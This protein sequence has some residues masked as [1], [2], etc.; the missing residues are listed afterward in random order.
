[1]KNLYFLPLLLS[2]TP[3][4]FAGVDPEVHKICL[5]ARDYAGCIKSLPSGFKKDSKIKRRNE[6]TY[7][8]RDMPR[9]DDFTKESVVYSWKYQATDRHAKIQPCL[10]FLANKND[11][12]HQEICSLTYEN[13]IKFR[14]HFISVPL[15][16]NVVNIE[17]TLTNYYNKNTDHFV[18]YEIT[19]LALDCKLKKQLERRVDYKFAKNPNQKKSNFIREKGYGEWKIEAADDYML[20]TSC[21]ENPG[22]SRAN[23]GSNVLELE[24]DLENIQSNGDLKIIPIFTKGKEAFIVNNCKNNNWA[25]TNKLPAK[26]DDFMPISTY[27]HGSQSNLIHQLSCFNNNKGSFVDKIFSKITKSNSE[28]KTSAE[29]KAY[30]ESNSLVKLG[31]KKALDF[32]HRD[33]IPHYNK[34]IELN[35]KNADAYVSRGFAKFYLSGRDGACEDWKKGADLGDE[36]ALDLLEQFCR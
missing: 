31:K 6:I 27:K 15:S 33:A 1:M 7:F 32:N 14:D 26:K 24:Y 36:G 19:Q 23:V 30:F 22:Y 11:T 3:Y 8:K 34:A 10:K 29:E 9:F 2:L 17:H 20:S 25:M 28:Q 21:P 13:M 16:K 5:E 4:S 12:Y 18:G 35:P